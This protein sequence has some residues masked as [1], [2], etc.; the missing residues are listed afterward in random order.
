M[1]LL[2]RVERAQRA[3]DAAARET[4]NREAAQPDDIATG[5]PPFAAGPGDG[6][7]WIDEPTDIVPRTSSAGRTPRSAAREALLQEIRER[8]QVKVVADFKALA[9]VADPVQIQAKIAGMVDRIIVDGTYS[10]TREER[11][12]LVE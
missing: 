12:S 1:S 10:V 9:D 8:V 6:A 5:S 7:T 4:A 2:Q 3:A 11:V